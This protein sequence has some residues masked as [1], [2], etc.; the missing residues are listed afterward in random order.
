MSRYAVW[1][2]ERLMP[3]EDK[4]VDESIFQVERVKARRL[5]SIDNNNGLGIGS[6]CKL[7]DFLYWRHYAT[8]ITSLSNTND[9]RRFRM[10]HNLKIFHLALIRS[11]CKRNLSYLYTLC[12]T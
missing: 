11:T 8:D 10:K 12:L 7:R 4:S 2:V 3:R 1:T 9:R 5:G 6:F